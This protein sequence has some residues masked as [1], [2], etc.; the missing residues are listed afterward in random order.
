MRS[1]MSFRRITLSLG[2]VSPLIIAQ[3]T[4]H[5]RQ[6]PGQIGSPCPLL[7]CSFSR[8]APLSVAQLRARLQKQL[9]ERV[10]RMQ[11][12]DTEG[13][14]ALTLARSRLSEEQVEALERGESL[15]L[16][17]QG[18]S[19]PLPMASVTGLRMTLCTSMRRCA[20]VAQKRDLAER[21][22]ERFS[23]LR[24]LRP[25]DFATGTGQGN[26]GVPGWRNAR[27]GSDGPGAGGEEEKA[28]SRIHREQTPL[29][30]YRQE[31]LMDHPMMQLAFKRGVH[32]PGP[33]YT[34]D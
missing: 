31:V 28:S 4:R 23:Q 21:W 5:Q 26:S 9:Q 34:G 22:T 2:S 17:L 25:D 10:P 7:R 15:W 19:S 30:Q 11:S 1:F 13:Q 8:E 14:L 32:D 27:S 3:Q 29:Q 24:H 33:R 16:E 12:I 20:L 18:H 6:L